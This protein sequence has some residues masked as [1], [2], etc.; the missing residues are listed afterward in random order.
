MSKA[1]TLNPNRTEFMLKLSR[2]TDNPALIPTPSGLEYMPFQK[3]GIVYASLSGNVL[4]GDEPGLGKT[5]QSI[6]TMNNLGINRG[7]I[8]CPAS[9]CL[10][11]KNEIE[12]WHINK[13]SV[14]ILNRKTSNWAADFLVV[15]FGLCSNANWIKQIL[16]NFNYNHLT[17]DECHYLK[18]PKAKRTKHV[19]AR[20]GLRSKAKTAHCISGTPIVNRP[21][22]IYPIIKAF[23]PTAIDNFSFFQYALKYC[24]AHKNGFGWNFNGATNLPQLGRKLRANFMVRRKKEAVLKDLP[25]KTI[26]IAYLDVDPKSK[27]LINEYKDF[28]EDEL[29]GKKTQKVSF[30]HIATHRRELGKAKAPFVVDYVKTQLECGHDKILLFAHHTEVMDILKEGLSEFGVVEIRGS[31][32]S[33]LRGRAVECF[34]GNKGTRVFLGSITAAGVGLTLTAGSYVLFAEPSYVPGEN[35][36]AMD[37]AHR[38]G[39]KD[40]VL[41]EFLVQ[42]GSLDERVL[43]KVLNKQKNIDEV[44]E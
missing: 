20:N 9:L 6:G 7:L 41:V 21:I 27:K 16:Q 31:T 22:E 11:W 12:K 18:N 44:L 26:N 25:E 10:N 35:F 30:E 40:H 5:I 17:I 13:P 42:K 33:A 3:A 14:E 19:L 1:E 15:S 28:N 39:Q 29:F 32:P 2:A 8:L 24:G 23:R 38:I 36:Q 43:K 34:Q 4:F 37:R